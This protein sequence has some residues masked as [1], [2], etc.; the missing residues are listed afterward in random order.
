MEHQSTIN[1]TAGHSV[2]PG[3]FINLT[4][5]DTRWWRRLW[6]R[7]LRRGEPYRTIQRRVSQVDGGT[8]H[9]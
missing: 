2:K 8:L 1:T 5:R 9:L 3:D 4:V 6:F 7:L